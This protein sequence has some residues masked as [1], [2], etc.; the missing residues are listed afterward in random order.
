MKKLLTL[1]AVFLI[2]SCSTVPLTGRKQITWIPSSQMLNLSYQSYNQDLQERKLS[3]NQRYREMVSTVGNNIK[4][5]V[6]EY[7]QK[8]NQTEALENYRWEFRVLAEDVVNAWAMPGGKVAFYEGIMP[9]CQDENGVA[10]VMGHEIAHAVA[11]HGNERMTQ[12]LV[13]QGLGTALSVALQNE[14]QQTQEIAL[15]AYGVGSTVLGTL[16]YSR[17]HESEADKLGLVFMSLAGYDPREAPEFWKRMAAQ[18]GGGSP[19]EFL[20]T[21]PSYETRIKNLNEWIPEVMNYY[22]ENN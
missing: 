1:I 10:V 3:D 17:L 5:A 6:Q 7:F 20:S 19:P 11:E 4:N 8:I 13:Q 21:H 15:A 16:P 14:P 18:G 12:G 2:Y 22:R 9:I